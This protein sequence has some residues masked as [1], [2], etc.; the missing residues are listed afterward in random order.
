MSNAA[1]VSTK[2]VCFITFCDTTGLALVELFPNGFDSLSLP[3]HNRG[4]SVRK[5][6]AA[7]RT[8]KI[9]DFARRLL[10]EWR[11]LGLPTTDEPIIVAV[12]GG[13][14]STALFLALDE[15]KSSDKIAAQ[16]VVAH[17]DHALRP[18]SRRE[19]KWV[20][21]LAK[22]HGYSAVISRA[23]VGEIAEANKDNLE[24]VARRL[25]YDFL[26]R[27][28]KR[29]KARFVLTGHTMDDQAET[30]LLRLMRGSASVGLGGIPEVRALSE[31]GDIRLVRPLLWARRADTEDYCR[32]RRQEFLQDEMNR[33][34]TYARVRVRK[35]LLPLME[36]FN[37]RVVEAISRSAAL[38]SEDTAELQERA[39]E[40]LQ[41]ATNQN[42]PPTDK[43]KHHSLDVKV[44][45][46]APSALRRRALR[47]WITNARGSARRLEMVHLVAVEKLLEGTAGGRVVE[48]PGGAKVR[49]L[50]GK[51]EVEA[52]VVPQ[53]A[54]KHW[55]RR[56]KTN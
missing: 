13:A 9:S 21:N 45:S 5:R 35:Q 7:S 41:K 18:G 22:S 15:L 10:A 14:D 1:F 31:S 38:L 28:A 30:V 44:L 23:K 52:S 8:Q 11:K 17:L 42:N 20:S 12:S 39:A 6:G 16:V 48:L 3:L 50:R 2:C 47:H 4:M 40:L 37:A 55:R 51:L 34:E 32:E 53:N 19:A 26:E 27:T 49:R 25:R 56:G 24:Q 43:S 54:S 33:D 29:K 36:S 46:A